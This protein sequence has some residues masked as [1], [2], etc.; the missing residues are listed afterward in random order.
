MVKFFTKERSALVEVISAII[1]I[2]VAIGGI[3]AAYYTGTAAAA[4]DVAGVVTR[5][6]ILETKQI[7][8]DKDY[9]D[10]SASLKDTNK[11]VNSVDRNL[12]Y[13][14]GKISIPPQN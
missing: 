6:S 12:R 11:T 13:L 4:S 7:Q 2:I 5:V 10:L 8:S 9:S 3:V 14:M 1:A